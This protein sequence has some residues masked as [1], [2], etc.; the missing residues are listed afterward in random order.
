MLSKL[1]STMR[2][3]MA[4]GTEAPRLVGKAQKPLFSTVR[5]AGPGEPTKRIATV[6]ILL[7]HFLNEWT[8][9]TVLIWNPSLFIF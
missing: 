9:E 7:Y 8:K 6:E 3:P 4:G 5:T 2:L 1:I